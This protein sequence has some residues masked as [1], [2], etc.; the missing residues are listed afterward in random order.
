MPSCV[1]VMRIRTWCSAEGRSARYVRVGKEKDQGSI[2]YETSLDRPLHVN[3]K[4]ATA[5][6]RKMKL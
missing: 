1:S 3:G 5:L 4:S 6:R 2:V